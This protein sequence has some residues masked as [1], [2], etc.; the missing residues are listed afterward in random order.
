M[1][2]IHL[3]AV[4]GI[5]AIALALGAAPQAE[6]LQAGSC[7]RC[8]KPSVSLPYVE[9]VNPAKGGYDALVSVC[10]KG[11]A[12]LKVTCKGKRVKARKL[13]AHTWHVRIKR[14]KTYK[15]SARA[16][17]GKWKSIAYRVY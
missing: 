17:G 16:K 5:I 4:M 3:G 6:A 7:S 14:G 9:D 13:D 1:K 8:E 10:G 2:R 11:K 15:I 12:E